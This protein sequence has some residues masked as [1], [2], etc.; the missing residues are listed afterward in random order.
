[1]HLPRCYVTLLIKLSSKVSESLNI[2]TI[3]KKTECII[4]VFV[5]ARNLVYSVYYFIN[6]EFSKTVYQITKLITFLYQARSIMYLLYSGASW[7]I[8]SGLILNTIL[9]CPTVFHFEKKNA[10]T[11]PN[12]NIYVK[13]LWFINIIYEYI[14]IYIVCSYIIIYI[15]RTYQ[16]YKL[17]LFFY[18]L[19]YK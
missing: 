5:L 10:L 3:H 2:I 4:I 15:Y 7:K 17:F 8:L 6:Y 14:F 1:M 16:N 11:L 13:K 9:L 19:T 18:L 12:H